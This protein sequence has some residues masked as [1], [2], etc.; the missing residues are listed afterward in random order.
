MEP[1]P[2]LTIKIKR[3]NNLQMC[4]ISEADSKNL[5]KRAISESSFKKHLLKQS[6]FEEISMI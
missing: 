6:F 4:W 1:Q 3:K 5:Q 2:E